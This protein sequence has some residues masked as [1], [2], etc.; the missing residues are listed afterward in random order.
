MIN[1]SSIWKDVERRYRGLIWDNIP[2]SPQR[3]HEKLSLQ[4]S[5]SMD[6]DLNPESEE[7][8]ARVL[9]TRP[10]RSVC[11]LLLTLL[12]TRLKLITA[13]HTNCF[14]RYMT[15]SVIKFFK[16]RGGN[17][18]CHICMKKLIPPITRTF[19]FKILTEYV[20][21]LAIVMKYAA[22]CHHGT[23][24]FCEP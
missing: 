14:Y 22:I 8:E 13:K 20:I 6:R 1:E 11:P 2:T 18:L 21:N 7:H 24:G 3:A 19:R 17:C 16:L 5:R 12:R 9:T 23:H 10:Q 4:D 15:D